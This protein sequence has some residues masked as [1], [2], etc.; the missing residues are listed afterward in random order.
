MLIGSQITMNGGTAIA[1]TCNIPGYSGS[2]SSG[3]AVALVQ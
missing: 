2:G 3:G 1:S